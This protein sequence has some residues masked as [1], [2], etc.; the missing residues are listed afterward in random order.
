MLS[1]MVDFLYSPSYFLHSLSFP[2]S[3]FILP[4]YHL[5]ISIICLHYLSFPFI[6]P[7]ISPFTLQLY[8]LY[9]SIVS[10]NLPFLPFF[11]QLPLVPLYFSISSCISPLYT[12][13]FL[14]ISFIFLYIDF[15]FPSLSFMFLYVEHLHWPPSGQA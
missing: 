15:V 14:Y 9:I 13:I 6:F 2:P 5:H 3:S 10:F 1:G 4:S 11:P 7:F 8:F 12:L